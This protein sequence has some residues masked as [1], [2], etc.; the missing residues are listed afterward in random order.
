MKTRAAFTVGLAALASVSLA[1]TAH[2]SVTIDWTTIGNPG[3]PADPTTGFGAVAYEY[4]ISKHEVTNTQYCEFLNAV[5]PD[6][7]NPHGLFNTSMESD[8]RGG[9]AFTAGSATG[10]KYSVKANMGNKPVIYV[11]WF[12]AA[13]FANW[14]NNGQDGANTELG[15]YTLN[16]DNGYPLRNP[17]ARIWITSENEWY[18]AAYYDP[19]PG[20]GGGDNYWSF[21]TRGNALE[22]PV[23]ATA[24]STGDVSNP[25]PR[26]ANYDRSASWNGQSGNLT[27]VGSAGSTSYYGT[28]DQDGN[29]WEFFDTLIG[30]YRGIRGGCWFNTVNNL[31]STMRHSN[32]PQT[33]EN[34][35]MGIRLA[36]HVNFSGADDFNDNSQNTLWWG[37]D[38]I[39]NGTPP[40]N[41]GEAYLT[42]TNCRIEYTETSGAPTGVYSA[43]RPWIINAGSYV[44]GWE[45]R[46]DVHLTST[47]AT[48]DP[49]DQAAVG[50]RIDAPNHCVHLRF[51]QI[52]VD[53][54]IY[55]GVHAYNDGPGAHG[56]HYSINSA[57]ISLRMTFDAATKTLTCSFDGDGA[58]DGYTWTRLHDIDMDDS[59]T[60]WGLHEGSFLASIHGQSSGV[61]IASGDITIDNF[62]L[63]P[64]SLASEISV[65]A[66]GGATLESGAS[67]AF[68]TGAVGGR[69]GKAFTIRN[70]GEANL[71][72]SSANIVGGDAPDFTITGLSATLLAPGEQ[73]N[74]N[75]YFEPSFAGN[76]STVLRIA[77]NDA[78]ENP[79]DLI[80][81][82]TAAEVT[83]LADTD[84]D[85]LSDAFEAAMF[86]FGF[87]WQVAQPDMAASLFN[88]AE[89]AG[90]FTKDQIQAMNVATPLLERDPATGHFKLNIAMKKSTDLLNFEPFAI[91]GA[92][93]T[94]TP[95]GAIQIDFSVP[96]KAAFFRVE[97]N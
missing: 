23:R 1:I 91:S 28:Y 76:K 63:S 87:D 55:R 21:A 74:F 85:G 80:L 27:T 67:V 29:L 51:E 12:D 37:P 22:Y 32:I 83:A 52:N 73:T 92:N 89:N 36:T 15:A 20:A 72:V 78:N 2:A 50:M 38:S 82:G 54:V 5:D 34:D 66:S 59:P 70:L 10:S 42:E 3:N 9:I 61:V 33:L 56:A 47:T 77:N 58:T 88:H 14:L 41:N 13:R 81:T 46:M 75:V 8:A 95:E 53:G 6:G 39:Q 90:L 24:N 79:F 62:N 71:T 45:I 18:K 30:T 48:T 17:T 57:D 35:N 49:G 31:P 86:P 97:S 65:E 19:T 7:T 11:S 64:W 94:T 4:K 96:D 44:Q 16:D 68:G 40:N 69:V 43:T 60:N 25:G 84:G 26:V 93:I